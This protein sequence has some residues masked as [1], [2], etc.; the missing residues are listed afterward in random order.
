LIGCLIDG[1]LA[2]AMSNIPGG[3]NVTGMTRSEINHVIMNYLVTGIFNLGPSIQCY[4]VNL[5]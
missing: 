3:E 2:V 4:D 5:F 1:I